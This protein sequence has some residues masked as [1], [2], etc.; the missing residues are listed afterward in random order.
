MKR[1]ARMTLG[2]LGLSLGLFLVA[3]PAFADGM[4]PPTDSGTSTPA[5]P[6]ANGSDGMPA[7]GGTGC[8]TPTTSTNVNNNGG[9]NDPGPSI[10]VVPQD[11]PAPQQPQ[12]PAAPKYTPP[13]PK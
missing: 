12:S 1:I 2:A 13:A 7:D 6:S 10:Y 9:S 4:M 11:D 3:G 5:G 8:C